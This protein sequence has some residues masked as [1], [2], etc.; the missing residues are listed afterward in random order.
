MNNGSEIEPPSCYATTMAESVEEIEKTSS[1][2]FNGHSRLSVLYLDI[3][4]S[5]QDDIIGWDETQKGWVKHLQI[6]END[7][8]FEVE[9]KNEFTWF[10]PQDE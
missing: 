7:I 4:R 10:N 3:L 9:Y 2:S 1:N 5:D 6:D 8:N